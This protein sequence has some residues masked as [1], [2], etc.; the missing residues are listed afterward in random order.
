MES[1]QALYYPY[2]HFKNDAWVKLSALYWD[3]LKRIVP[4][5]YPTEDSATV[6]GLAAS[7]KRFGR[8]R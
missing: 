3:K 7:S 6:R 5:G 4:E 8:T 1:Y 2:V